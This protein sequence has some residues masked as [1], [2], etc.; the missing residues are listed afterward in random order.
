MDA[1][2][3]IFS[4]WGAIIIPSIVVLIIATAPIG[5]AGELKRRVFK[6]KLGQA[7]LEVGDRVREEGLAGQAAPPEEGVEQEGAGPEPPQAV[8]QTDPQAGLYDALHNK[9]RDSYESRKA[10]IL[11]GIRDERERCKK[12]AWI[13][14]LSYLIADW[15]V[16]EELQRLHNLQPTIPEIPSYMAAVLARAMAYDDAER[17]YLKAI[18]LSESDEDRNRRRM[19]LAKMLRRAK[20]FDA[21]AAQL[22]T[23]TADVMRAGS[24]KE[25]FEARQEWGELMLAQDQMEAAQLMFEEALTYQPENVALRFNV[26]YRYNFKLDKPEMAFYHYYICHRLDPHDTSTLNNL[27][28][29]YIKLGMPMKGVDMLKRA[30]EAGE[31]LAMANVADELQKA[32]FR[33]EAEGWIDRA[34]GAEEKYPYVG[35]VLG[36]IQNAAQAEDTTESELLA[37]IENQRSAR[38][39]PQTGPP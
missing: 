2:E 3:A 6:G 36:Q 25:R 31:G 14:Y 8:A 33:Q 11:D 34:C 37:R 4:P 16:L 19:Q 18:E 30:S 13:V 21:A 28:G 24:D 17:A 15:Q 9:D 39:P 29:L 38:T 12:E 32:G 20:R 7:E 27:G 23:L 26:A 10:E 22:R 1:L 35:T 5:I